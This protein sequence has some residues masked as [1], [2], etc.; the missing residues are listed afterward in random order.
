MT[1]EIK[2]EN[3]GKQTEIISCGANQ[4]YMYFP[5][6]ENFQWLIRDYLMC[7]F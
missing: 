7:S 2:D 5:L 3:T 6:Y 1:E 4:I